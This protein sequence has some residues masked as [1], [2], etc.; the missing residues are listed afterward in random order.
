MNFEQMNEEEIRKAAKDRKIRNYHNKGLERLQKEILERDEQ[1][2]EWSAPDNSLPKLSW[3]QVLDCLDTYAM[4]HL[5]DSVEALEVLSKPYAKNF[6]GWFSQY[7]E[8]ARTGS[9][10]VETLYTGY[11][12]R[13]GGM[14]FDYFL[15][16]LEKVCEVYRGR[17]WKVDN[18][19]F[20]FTPASFPLKY[21]IEVWT[22][23]KK[24]HNTSAAT[25]I[26]AVLM[27]E[28]NE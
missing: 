5:S 7:I 27:G 18:K 26:L 9:L 25:R 21:H 8:I 13:H 14:S 6:V 17:G 19:T 24:L 23:T 10:D 22:L 11:K 4:K 2:G 20:H 16:L 15:V 12:L 3:S 28:N 1:T